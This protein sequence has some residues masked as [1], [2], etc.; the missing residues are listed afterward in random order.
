MEEDFYTRPGGRPYPPDHREDRR[1]FLPWPPFR[2]HL[3]SRVEACKG[4]MRRCRK[5]EVVRKSRRSTDE[6]PT[7]E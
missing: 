7:G 1:E 4:K 6:Q 3:L 5:V 2:S